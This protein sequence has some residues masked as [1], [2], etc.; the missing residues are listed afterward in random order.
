MGAGDQNSRTVG[1]E[2]TRREEQAATLAEP[3]PPSTIGFLLR[4]T[5]QLKK[6][7]TVRPFTTSQ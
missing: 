3:P 6:A 1:L 5:T 2:G 7:L 4:K